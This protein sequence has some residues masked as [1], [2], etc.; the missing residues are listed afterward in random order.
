MNKKYAFVV[1][2][3]LI[4]FNVAFSQKKAPENWFNLDPKMDKVYGVSTNRAYN[5][6]LKDKKSK[7]VIVAVIDGGTEVAQETVIIDL[8]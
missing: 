7:P 2:A 8:I 6:L 4:I 5:E 3:L 1:S